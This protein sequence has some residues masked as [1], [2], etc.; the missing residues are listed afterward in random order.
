MQNND[1]P[2]DFQ[3]ELLL[4][5]S[6]DSNIEDNLCLISNQPLEDNCITLSCGHKFNYAS[7]FNEI[8]SQK[9]QYNHLETQKLNNHEIKCPYCRTVQKGLLPSRN[10]F[11]NIIGVNWPKKY[12]YKAN[13]CPYVFLSGKK[14]GTT[15]GKK[16]FGKYCESHEK[17]ILKRENKQLLKEK[18]K[19]EKEQEKLLK[20]LNKTKQNMK[21]KKEKKTGIP[22]CQYVYKRGKNKGMQCMCKKPF[23]TN[24]D[25]WQFPWYCKSHN[26]LISKKL[27]TKHKK[28]NKLKMELNNINLTT[29]K[30]KNVS[31]QGKNT[32]ITI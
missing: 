16:C 27:Q 31:I 26:K 6:Q 21:I 23:P 1:I 29:P 4:L 13:I 22:T 2:L 20:Q 18:K 14:K 24:H 19:L 8:K 32:I 17:I 15:C 28:E 25:V 5:L 12:Q 7:I 9:T 10:N 11:N 30:I 3:A